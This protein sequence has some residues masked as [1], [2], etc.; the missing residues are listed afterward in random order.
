MLVIS[1]G[2][3]SKALLTFNPTIRNTSSKISTINSLLITTDSFGRLIGLECGMRSHTPYLLI[4]SLINEDALETLTHIC[5]I[6]S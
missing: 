6:C 2:M 5:A 3:Y 1:V 4:T